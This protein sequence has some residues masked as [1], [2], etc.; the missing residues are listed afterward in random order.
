MFFYFN[1]ALTYLLIGTIISFLFFLFFKRKSLK[2]FLPCLLFGV[3][4]SF[5]GGFL[6]LFITFDPLKY[7]SFFKN[8]FTISIFMPLITSIVVVFFYSIVAE[9]N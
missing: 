7:F 1:V 3:I 4:G 6:N 2:H 9:N 8:I 5:L